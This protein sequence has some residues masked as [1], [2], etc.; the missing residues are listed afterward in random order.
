MPRYSLAHSP[1][2]DDLFMVAPLML[3]IIKSQGMT[4]EAHALDIQTLNDEALKGTFDITAISFAL[5]PLIAQ[6][7]ALLRTQASFGEGYGPKL[8]KRRGEH[9]KRRFKVALSGRH[10]TNALLFKIRYPD[11]KIVYKNFLEIEGAILSGEVDAGILI[12]E[13]IL[14]YSDALE[15][16]GEVWQWWQELV[17]KELPLPL[18]GMVLRRSIPL[19]RAIEIE[20]LLT[21]AVNASQTHRHEIAASLAKEGKLRIDGEKLERYLQ[22]YANERSACLDEVSMEALDYLWRIGWE[23]GFYPIPIKTVDYLI[24][25]D[26]H[27]LRK[28]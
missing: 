4:F 16:E 24:P 23:K 17:G 8:V 2:A 22:M 25:T 10:T 7:Y 21:K 5:Y 18:G 1:D 19:M 11:A 28:G 12:H 26:Y 3:G 6:E 20:E 27:E 14:T 15:V 9:L 13:A